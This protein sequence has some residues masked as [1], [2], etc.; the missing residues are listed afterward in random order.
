MAEA[1]RAGSAFLLAAPLPRQVEPEWLDALPAD[2]PRAERSRRDLRRVNALML[3]ARIMARALRRHAA[4]PPRRMLDLGSG[5]GTFMLKVARRLAPAWREVRLTLLDRHSIVSNKTLQGFADLGWQ[6]RAIADDVF[7][8]LG[9]Q[10]SEAA[11]IVTANLFLHHFSGRALAD[12]LEGIAGRAALFVACEPRRA[13][14]ALFASKRLGLIGCNAVSR[15]D[16]VASVRAGFRDQELSALWP[17]RARFALHES[18]AFLFTHCFVA[19]RF[20]GAA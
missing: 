3:E 12:L 17:D 18:E 20:R 13:G 6:A 1:A 19:R 4:A 7:H 8:Y 14:F 10:D 9:S 11:D 15:H 5:D 16:A 2:D